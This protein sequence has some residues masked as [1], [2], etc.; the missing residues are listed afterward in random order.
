M[1]GPPHHRVSRRCRGQPRFAKSFRQQLVVSEERGQRRA[2][3]CQALVLELV[4][5]HDSTLVR[6]P[7]DLLP[8]PLA[9]RK[10]TRLNSSHITISYAVF[11]LKKKKK[12]KNKVQH[13]PTNNRT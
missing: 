7:V 13:H 11:C 10:S 4:T 12:T 2:D 1:R 5:R 8:P 6:R 3:R 9:D